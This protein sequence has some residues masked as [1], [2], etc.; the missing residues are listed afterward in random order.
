MS[1]PGIFYFPPPNYSS[2]IPESM[3]LKGDTPCGFRLLIH[4]SRNTNEVW[5]RA[6]KQNCGFESYSLYRGFY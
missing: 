1:S 6:I 2:L 3:K 5:L 4:Q